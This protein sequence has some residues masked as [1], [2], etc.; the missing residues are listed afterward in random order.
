M[1]LPLEPHLLLAA[2]DLILVAGRR[3][4]LVAAAPA[5]GKE[6]ADDRFGELVAERVNVV[7]TRARRMA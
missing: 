2:G 5:F 4:A 7:L 3:E 1:S 6:V